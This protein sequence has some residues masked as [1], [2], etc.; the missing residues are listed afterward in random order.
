MSNTIEESSLNTTHYRNL[1]FLGYPNHYVD[2]FGNFWSKARS[3]RCGILT[4][5][6]THNCLG[7]RVVYLSYAGKGKTFR[8]HRV[9]LTA[10]VGP[11]PEGMECCHND[12]N[13][14]NNCLSNLRWDTHKANY[15]DMTKNGH[16]FQGERNPRAKLTSEQVVE[17]RRLY[18][19]GN[20]LQKHLAQ[21]F[22]IDQTV[23]SE[24]VRRA[25][26]KTVP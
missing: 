7:Y 23:V 17:I 18:S 19:T 14:N 4:K 25:I 21:M 3:W 26:W 22:G 24:I 5:I 2:I 6:R 8:A 13:P 16:G 9:V 12:G 11:C 15:A 20:Y 10:F 1:S